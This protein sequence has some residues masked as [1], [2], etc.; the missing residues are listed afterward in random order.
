MGGGSKN[1]SI[2]TKIYRVGYQIS[3]NVLKID[4]GCNEII[5][6]IGVDGFYK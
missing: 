5:N 6:N 3:W 1:V 4:D 2:E